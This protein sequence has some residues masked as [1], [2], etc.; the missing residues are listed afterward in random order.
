MGVCLYF[1]LLLGE[2]FCTLNIQ[3]IIF[4]KMSTSEA[5][6]DVN[7]A[8][9]EKDSSDIEDLLDDDID[10]PK[11]FRKS[12]DEALGQGENTDVNESL[13]IKTIKTSMYEIFQKVFPGERSIVQP[14]H[15]VSPKSQNSRSD[16]AGN[17]SVVNYITDQKSQDPTMAVPGPVIMIQ[18]I[19][20][21]I[22]ETQ[23]NRKLTQLML[24]VMIYYSKCPVNMNRVEKRDQRFRK[25]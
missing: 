4:A 19:R 9:S 8:V 11:V 20:I 1:I 10:Q 13:L 21:P 6:K 5:D 16:S 2:D 18:I 14:E 12:P 25:N 23:Q 24:R 15:C 3:G 17:Q 22:L 7:D